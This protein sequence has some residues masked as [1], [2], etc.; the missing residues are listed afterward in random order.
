MTMTTV[1]PYDIDLD[2]NPANFQPLTPLAFLERA[3]AT[4]PDAVA[5]IHG[6]IRQTYREFYAR[7]RRLAEVLTRHGVG[8]GDTVSVMLPNTPAMLE[9]HYGVPMSGGVLNALNIRL[10]A[11]LIAF[12]IDFAGA[13]VLLFDRE[14]SETV[15][16]AL[17]LV[18]SKPLV[19]AYD[20]PEYDGPGETL[21][22][23]TMSGSSPVAIQD[24]P[25][26]GRLTSGTPSRSTSPPAPLGIPRAWFTITAGH[27]CS[28]LAT[29]SPGRWA[30]TRSIS[31]HC[32]C[33]TATVGVFL[34]Q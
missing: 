23:S 17:A 31:G 21:E 9:C 8:R 10:D 34:G 7:S 16:N 33:S 13:K 27:I 11:A 15:K 30:I 12:Q 25:G 5:V 3:A 32:P 14:F 19:I 1:T 20:D 24:L 4:Y 28:R 2:R 6:K 22:A 18:K 29:F 26:G